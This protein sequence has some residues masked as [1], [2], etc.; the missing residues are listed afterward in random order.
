MCFR[1]C[2]RV[3]TYSQEKFRLLA[4]E[5]H[6][7]G[8]VKEEEIGDPVHAGDH[9]VDDV[10]IPPRPAPALLEYRI[11]AAVHRGELARIHTYLDGDPLTVGQEVSRFILL[12]AAV[13][14]DDEQQQG[15]DEEAILGSARGV[16]QP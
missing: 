16:A 2:A 6:V 5:C 11:T 3:I 14:R 8:Q 10:E 4:R 12:T 13:E 7:G 9:A 15:L 1:A